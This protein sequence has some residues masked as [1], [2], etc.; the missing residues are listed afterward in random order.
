[1]VHSLPV[2]AITTCLALGAQPQ[3][4]YDTSR[5]NLEVEHG[6]LLR[7]ERSALPPFYRAKAWRILDAARDE[8]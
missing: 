1:M 6:T 7:Y 2:L 5:L 4:F 8:E 3:N